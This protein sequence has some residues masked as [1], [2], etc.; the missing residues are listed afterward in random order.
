MP[1]GHFVKDWMSRDVISIGPNTKAVQAAYLLRNNRIR[2]LPVAEGMKVVGVV[3]DRDLRNPVRALHDL[4]VAQQYQSASDIPVRY[5][6][7]T[8]LITITQQDH[9]ITA[10]YLLRQNRINGL[11]VLESKDQSSLVGVITT[12]DLLDAFVELADVTGY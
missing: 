6:M 12:T 8:N 5:F 2:F 9:I 11:P 1:R 10:A 4:E 7:A 3:T